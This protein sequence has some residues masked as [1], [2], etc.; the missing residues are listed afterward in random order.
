MI[1][2]IFRDLLILTAPVFASINYPPIPEDL[3]TPFQVRLAVNGRYAID[4]NRYKAVAVGWNTYEALNESCVTYGTSPDNLSSRSC[5]S[6]SVTYSTSRTWSNM[7][8]LSG[9]DPA[10]AYYYKIVSANSSVEPFFSPRIPGDKTPFSMNVVSDLGVY[11][12]D[13]FTVSRREAIPYV[14]PELNHTTI[15]RLAKTLNDYEVVIHPGDFAYADDWYLK[16]PS[17]QEGQMTYQSILE[18]FYEQLAPITG[19]KIYMA[20]PGNHEAD[21]SEVRRLL[22]LCPEGQENF[23]DFKHHFGKTMPQPFTSSSSNKSAQTQ[24][25]KA[26]SFARPPFWY[27]FEYGMAHVVMINTETDFPNAPDTKLESGPFGNKGEQLEFLDADLSSVDRAVTPWVIVAGHRPWYST[28]SVHRCESCQ[29]AF[30]NLLYKYG[31]DLAVF[32]HVHNS[33]R[34]LPVFNGIADPRGMQNPKAP[35]YIICGGAGNI[36]GLIP[37]DDKPSYTKFAYADEYSYST[38]KF[39]DDK[40]LQIDFIRS[41]N[42]DILDSSTLYKSHS[43]PFV[44]Q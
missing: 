24:S 26:R 1:R 18:Q 42:G 19:H 20:S 31:V 16:L 28:D 36:E 8:V 27:S 38:L 32:G 35:M 41:S 43:I 23:T 5:S 39:L 17:A 44:T 7:V 22:K 30:E 3:T 13:G 10:T 11:G 25:D 37:I 6:S 2:A 14:Q 29:D 34:L 15:G 4:K 12:K 9:L 21:C 33:Q 40:H